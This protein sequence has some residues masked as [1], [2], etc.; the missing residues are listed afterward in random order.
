[1][2]QVRELARRLYGTYGEW[3]EANFGV[4]CMECRRLLPSHTGG[5]EAGR[6]HGVEIAKRPHKIRYFQ[7]RCGDCG[8]N[9]EPVVATQPGE[10]AAPD[11]ERL[12]E[13]FGQSVADNFREFIRLH[14]GHQMR[15]VE[16][17]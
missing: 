1:M 14:S 15:E 8:V 4:I 7:L 13:Q 2:A 17:K 6:R 3:V 10:L 16:C 5:C 11:L 9:Y 12:T